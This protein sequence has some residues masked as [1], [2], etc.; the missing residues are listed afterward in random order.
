VEVLDEGLV[1]TSKDPY[2][3]FKKLQLTKMMFHGDYGPTL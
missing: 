2:K 1:M 3:Q